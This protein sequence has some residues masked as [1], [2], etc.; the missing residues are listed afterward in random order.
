MI[1]RMKKAELLACVEVI[2]DIFELDLITSP[3]H[4][5]EQLEYRLDME[6]DMKFHAIE[7]V[8][9]NEATKEKL[10]SGPKARRVRSQEKRA[11]LEEKCA[12]LRR[13]YPN[14]TKTKIRE[15]ANQMMSKKFSCTPYGTRE[16]QKIKF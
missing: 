3:Q 12:S 8:F 6:S 2:K 9:E 5:R 14:W 11:F 15:R 16:L 7:A 13:R 4:L 10:H 1:K